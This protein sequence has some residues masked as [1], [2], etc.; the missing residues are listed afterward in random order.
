MSNLVGIDHLPY[1]QDQIE[2][3]QSILGKFNRTPEDQVWANGS[4]S[5][6]KLASGVNIDDQDIYTLQDS[7]TAESSSLIQVSDS[8]SDFRHRQLDLGINTYTGNKLAEELV[9]MGGTL[10]RPNSTDNPNN[11]RFPLKSSVSNNSSTTPNSPFNYGFGGNEF[12]LKPMPG[13]TSFNSKT[14][15]NGSLR[16]A[17]V[18]ILAHN[19]TQFQYLESLYL[20][21]GYTM[22][23][24]WGNTSY[25]ISATEY[26]A[27]NDASTLSL[28]NEFLKG[29]L[30]AKYYTLIEENRRLSKGN[31]DGFLGTV[32]NFSWEFTT[33]G[34]YYITLNLL[35]QGSIIESLK[36][37]IPTQRISNSPQA[38]GDEQTDTSST[39]K[40][41]DKEYENAL[42]TII[43]ALA[44]PLDPN[45]TDKVYV[46]FFTGNIQESAWFTSRGVDQVK[47]EPV[48][49]D[50]DN[51]AFACCAIFGETKFVKYLR[52][53]DLLDQ[54][55][56][57][58][59]LYGENGEDDPIYFSIDTSE[60][61]YCYSNGYSISS[62]PSK[63][64][65]RQ[66]ETVAGIPVKIFAGKG[67]VG[68]GEEA[69]EVDLNIEPFHTKVDNVKV[70]NIMNLYF[71][72]EYLIQEIK[73]NIDSEDNLSL[74]TFLTKLLS[75]ASN[76]LGGVNKFRTRLV[77]KNIKGISETFSYMTPDIQQVFEIYD[78]VQPYN[79]N[80]IL[81]ITEPP[82]KDGFQIYG[83][84]PIG[85][86]DGVGSFVTDYSLK[87]EISK[88]LET[89]IAIG[90]Q[91]NGTGV[92]VDSTIF[93]KWNKGLVDR[94]IPKKLSKDE[95]L[96]QKED[97]L[98]TATT[99]YVKFARLQTQY[100]ETLNLFS[101]YTSNV[102]FKTPK[103]KDDEDPP[104]TYYTGYGFPDVFLTAT[105]GQINFTKF[106]SLQKEY[107]TKALSIDALVKQVASPT[108]GFLPI[109][110]S[111]TFDGLSGIKIFDKLEV[112][113]GFL[114]SNY[115]GT[116]EFIITELDHYIENNK[117]FTKVGTLSIP[118]M[119]KS[120]NKQAEI[121]IEKIFR[122]TVIFDDDVDQG[123]VGSK[124]YGT[125]ALGAKIVTIYY[126]AKREANQINKRGEFYLPEAGPKNDSQQSGAGKISPLVKIGE[127]GGKYKFKTSYNNVKM[128]NQNEKYRSI[129]QNQYDGN[130]YLAR[131]AAFA[132][133]SLISQ[134]KT[135]G[136]S[137]TIS[138]AYRNTFHNKAAGGATD[139]AHAYGGAIDILELWTA[140]DPQGSVGIE[141]NAIVRNSNSLYKWLEENG[142]K[143]GW[144]NPYRLRS[145]S[146][147]KNEVWHWEFW[148]VPEERYSI[149]GFSKTNKVQ[150]TRDS[151]TQY[152]NIP[153]LED[154]PS[155]S[156][157]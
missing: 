53:K 57:N 125:S 157:K 12:G 146:S 63:M 148:G 137:F 75:T 77:E 43:E 32:K 153:K 10:N 14:Y 35:A 113:S 8:G 73:N 69:T 154:S 9:L 42:I 13:I 110:L 70:G 58:L 23:L 54:I 156:V 135:D 2:L 118:K 128:S 130:Y 22:L 1:V 20:R 3:R 119:N 155:L 83:I 142:P 121:D 114:P 86:I 122:S 17:T 81:G 28:V 104:E 56:A 131:P 147:R 112:N 97:I 59:L 123:T 31:Y 62:D 39:I 11:I 80:T 92:G 66:D 6:V 124:S 115:G 68:E 126:S 103:A 21:L 60:D 109:N 140:L 127:L 138:S 88:K 7:D 129:F 47:Y 65:I 44:A 67:T 132:L 34:T 5:W 100:L 72:T 87:T 15:N 37:A 106:V 18:T 149:S 150:S 41:S 40:D 46:N 55:N 85:N 116:L 90:A 151:A 84:D 26:S 74:N 52:F 48:K 96:D 36:V 139:S 19:K 61:L 111:L 93:S 30:E 133:T 29:G 78:E 120:N 79:K 51:K 64:I 145:S 134:A 24:E 45:T 99:P 102:E 49:R 117:W 4:T 98:K 105:E 108:I 50:K 27:V 101:E 38:E 76:L 71:S 94:I 82:I 95:L 89:M 25:P 91:A 136:I 144:Y 143:Y 107:F 152:F 141:Q 33:E 16:E